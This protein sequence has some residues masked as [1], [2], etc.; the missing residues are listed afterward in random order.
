[1]AYCTLRAHEMCENQVLERDFSRF[2]GIAFYFIRCFSLSSSSLWGFLFLPQILISPSREIQ[3]REEFMVAAVS[4]GVYVAFR[5]LGHWSSRKYLKALKCE[6]S[7][8]TPFRPLRG[9][10]F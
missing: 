8:S 2:F 5:L 3:K 7:P 1:M 6:L 9:H 4:W 10:N